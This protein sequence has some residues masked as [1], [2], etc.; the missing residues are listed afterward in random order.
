MSRAMR[1]ARAFRSAADELANVHRSAR[2]AVMD[3]NALLANER[4]LFID[5]A[6]RDSVGGG[7]NLKFTPRRE[8]EALPE[9]LRHN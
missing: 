1:A 7:F 2:G 5:A 9:G 3:E 8:V 4:R 6:K